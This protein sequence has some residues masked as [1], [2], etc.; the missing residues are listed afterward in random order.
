[1]KNIKKK[2]I[3]LLGS[4]GSIGK[5]SLKVISQ[6]PKHF[7]VLY[8][9]ANRNINDLI[10]QA[11]QYRPR[12][13]V[14]TDKKLYK[15]LKTTL[16]GICKVFWGMG[17]IL[18][19]LQD[20]EINL[21]LNSLVG[22]IGIL[23]TYHSIQLG[24]DV[25]LANKETLVAAGQLIMKNALKK[26]VKILP[27]DSE[28][29]A[30]WQCILGED[31]KNIKRIILTASGGPFRNWSKEKLFEITREQALLHPN[32]DMG[33]KI[34]I[35]SATLMNKGL[36]IIEAFWLY[37]VQLRQ[38]EVVIHPQS[39]IHSMVEFK[40]GS[41]KAQ[42]GVPDMKI[43]IQFAL[44]YPDRLTLK[45]EYIS[46]DKYNSLTFERPDLKKFPCLKI[47]IDAIKAG[48]TYPAVMNAANEVAVNGFLNKQI[49][50]TDI[51]I[52]I[53]ETMENHSPLKEYSI[54]ELLAVEKESKKYATNLL[55]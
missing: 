4:T 2:Q 39:I 11:K 21:V 12:G 23:P 30:I 41:I 25:A 15:E 28:H 36:E 47:A 6:H 19:V 34:T 7:Q 50:F 13:V 51:P 38:I 27:I 1:V 52:I 24:K 44:S 40:D 49:R 9:T 14:I 33:E 31:K 37:N 43:P 48:G 29:S 5:N 22:G 53:S 17:G 45:T 32:W 35:D 10:L 18:E 16:S 8:L 20:P 26:R 46:F 3:A 54:D 55:N 42:M